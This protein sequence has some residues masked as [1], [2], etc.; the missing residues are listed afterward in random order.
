M[1]D[2]LRELGG[3]GTAEQ[4]SEAAVLP[5]WIVRRIAAD[6][7]GR[8]GCEVAEEGRGWRWAVAAPGCVIRLV[9]G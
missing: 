7:P 9:G 4:V 6:H 5:V 3:R 1:A 2:A 8:F